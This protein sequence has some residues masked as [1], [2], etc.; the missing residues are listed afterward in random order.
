MVTKK[1]TP[2][3]TVAP[4]KTPAKRGGK[5]PG[6]AGRPSKIAQ[7]ARMVARMDALPAV[8]KREPP[9]KKNPN[10]TPAEYRKRTNA[11]PTKKAAERILNGELLGALKNGELHPDAT[12]LDVMIEAMRQAYKI[13]GAILAAPF[14]K[15]AAPY[16]HGKINNIDLKQTMQPTQAAQGG[17]TPVKGIGLH[18]FLV[19]YVDVEDVTPKDKPDGSSS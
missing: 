13:G 16:V 19:D 14:A 8:V 3:K 15:E 9:R 12:P 17:D 1:T 2:A 11:P 18:K 10:E 4:A 6:Q 7:V 5:R